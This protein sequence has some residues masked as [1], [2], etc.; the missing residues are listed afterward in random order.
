MQV[1]NLVSNQKSM[2]VQ[3]RSHYELH[4]RGEFI[5]MQIS[6]TAGIPENEMRRKLSENTKNPV[7]T[8]EC[9]HDRRCCHSLILPG[10]PY[11]MQAPLSFLLCLISEHLNPLKMFSFFSPCSGHLPVALAQVPRPPPP[12]PEIR[13]RPAGHPRPPNMTGV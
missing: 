8:E 3:D 9:W 13:P 4:S 10:F 7:M 2:L 5:T 11:R 6:I 1:S 12:G